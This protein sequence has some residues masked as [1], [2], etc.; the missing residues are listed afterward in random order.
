MATEPRFKRRPA[1]PLQRALL[2]STPYLYH[3][4]LAELLRSRCVLLLT[5]RGRRSGKPR[6]TA[7]SF[8]PLGERL[9]VFSGW[10]VNSN[11][12]RNVLADPAVFVRVGR[13]S[14]R[15][16]ARLIDDPK[17]REELMRQMAAR[18]GSCGPPV[19]VRPLARVLFDYDAEIRM[20]IA[21]GG[22]L[23]VLEIIPE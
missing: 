15:A 6:T 10:G 1:S 4:P 3:G 16:T 20:A 17:Q 23:P 18:S 9:I 21:Q 12:Y 13:R 8:M 7:I 14:F 22:D 19:W 2:R 11:W 5:T